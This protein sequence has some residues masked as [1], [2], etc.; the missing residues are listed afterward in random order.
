M[1]KEEILGTIK[2]DLW[3]DCYEKYQEAMREVEKALEKRK[4]GEWLEKWDKDHFVILAY[5]CSECGNMMNIP[6][7]NFCPNCG[8]KMRPKGKIGVIS[9]GTKKPLAEQ[10]EDMRGSEN[11]V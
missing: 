9:S 11:G 5:E 10:L 1:T 8:A 2:G 4:Q 7:A 3:V 6:N